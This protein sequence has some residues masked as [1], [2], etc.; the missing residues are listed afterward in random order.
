MTQSKIP[1]RYARG[2]TQHER[3][4]NCVRFSGNPTFATASEN[5]PDAPISDAPGAGSAGAGGEGGPPDP[6]DRL[7]SILCQWVVD[8]RD[9][10][11]NLQTPF[12]QAHDA[13][14]GGQREE[15]SELLA[16]LRECLAMAPSPRMLRAWQRCLTSSEV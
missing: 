1:I 5:P 14:A 9:L 2:I 15:L 6:V 3:G 16:K 7:E 12:E 13:A 11:D 8:V 4:S 10:L